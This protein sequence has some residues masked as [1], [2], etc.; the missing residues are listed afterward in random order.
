MHIHTMKHTYCG[1]HDDAQA[2]TQERILFCVDL[3]GKSVFVVARK[4]GEAPP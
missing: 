4:E 3:N 2:L 1:Q